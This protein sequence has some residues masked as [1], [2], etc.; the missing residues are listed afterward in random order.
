[1]KYAASVKADKSSSA[2]SI[3]LLLLN[4]DVYRSQNQPVDVDTFE[5]ML[6]LARKLDNDKLYDQCKVARTRSIET[7]QLLDERTA[8][9]RQAKQRLERE[10]A[11]HV[12]KATELELQDNNKNNVL[13]SSG[14]T[15][16]VELRTE[17]GNRSSSDAGT[18]TASP[19]SVD[20]LNV[21]D[22][23]QTMDSSCS[24]LRSPSD[25]SCS[26]QSSP[27]DT[28]Y[29]ELR[30]PPG[31]FA[32]KDMYISQLMSVLRRRSY[33]G[34][35]S[36][37]LYSPGVAA[38]KDSMRDM[39]V[40]EYEEYLFN[41]GLITEDMSD[42]IVAFLPKGLSDSTMRGSR[43]SLRGSMENLNQILAES[44]PQEPKS[45]SLLRDMSAAIKDDYKAAGTTIAP[46]PSLHKHHGQTSPSSQTPTLNKHH[47][48]HRKMLKKANSCSLP[49]TGTSE[50]LPSIR[51]TRDIRSISM[52]TGSTESLPW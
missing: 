23:S 20:R 12:A 8:K 47:R 25:N 52:I 32:N 28:S 30:S 5:M 34:K 1:M 14:A 38:F 10:S 22:L 13:H 24:E 15:D 44:P 39:N 36:A 7:E 40:W 49:E 17:M 16:G 41:E 48:P 27:A 37:P 21:S 2:E 4:L 33:A 3:D 50:T 19:T 26:Y 31:A 51:E 29:S 6:D 45:G 43:E 46:A 9:L 11:R 18:C 42:R 35:P